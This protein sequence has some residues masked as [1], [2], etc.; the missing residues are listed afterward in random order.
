VSAIASQLDDAFNALLRE[1][2]PEVEVL[3]LPRGVPTDLPARVDVLL[4]A[5]DANLRRAVE[6]PPGWPYRLRWVQLASSGVDFYPPW[7]FADL[8]ITSARGTTADT[9]AEF[10]LAAMFAAAKELPGIW[11]DSAAH[12]QRR[13]L[14]MLAGSTLGLF[15]FGSIA[16][17]L[18]RKALALG[19]EVIALRRSAQPLEIPGVAAVADIRELFARADHLVLA[20]PATEQTR[21]VV[22]RQVLAAA[23]PGLHLINVARG[24][25]IDQRALLEALDAG[26]I[27]LASLDVTDPEPLPAG[28]PLYHHPRVRLSPHTSASSAQVYRNLAALV[29]DNHARLL[30]GQPLV[31]RVDLQRGY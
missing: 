26:H 5:P 13:D 29:A 6:P 27:G 7:L 31:N 9:I 14:P 28:H 18:A 3:S 30:A 22:N 21:Q 4:A 17:S 11:I 24:A 2:L 12:W 1:A 16:Q 10:A 15:G 23:K 20:A 8:P 25:L 19:M